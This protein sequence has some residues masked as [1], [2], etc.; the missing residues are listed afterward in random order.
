MKFMKALA[1]FALLSTGSSALAYTWGFTNVTNKTL[2]IKLVLQGTDAEF[3]NIVQPGRRTS[4]DWGWGNARAGFCLS[5]IVIGQYNPNVSVNFPGTKS[6]QLPR[7]TRNT[8]FF[9][10]SKITQAIDARGPWFFA[11]GRQPIR[12]P[13]VTFVKDEAW[14]DFDDKI[15]EAAEKLATGVANTAEKAAELSGNSID[16]LLKETGGIV[17]SIIELVK[18]GKCMSRHFDIIEVDKSIQLFTKK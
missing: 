1:V 5:S 10:D 12:E 3:F 7:D 4:F 15:S 2:V 14:G 16:G 8:K 11:L 9:D 17:T 6:G 18:T 13:K